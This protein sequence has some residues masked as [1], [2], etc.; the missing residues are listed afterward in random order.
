M[1]VSPATRYFCLSTSNFLCARLVDGL[2]KVAE[3]ILCKSVVYGQ[4]RFSLIYLPQHRQFC[5][6]GSTGPYWELLMDTGET[7]QAHQII[8]DYGV[9][10]SK[11]FI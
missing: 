3:Y 7:E 5:A 1:E 4:S 11:E 10:S 6:E 9:P 2:W 8:T